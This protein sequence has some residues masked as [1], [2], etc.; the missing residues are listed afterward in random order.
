[1]CFTLKYLKLIVGDCFYLSFHHSVCASDVFTKKTVD[2]VIDDLLDVK[3][4]TKIHLVDFFKESKYG[5]K[6]VVDNN[7]QTV[8]YEHSPQSMAV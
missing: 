3:A 4:Q 1:M 2:K 8:F 7:G 6:S 5:S